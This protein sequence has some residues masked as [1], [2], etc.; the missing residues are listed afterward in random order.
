MTI[1]GF[2]FTAAAL[3]GLALANGAD[4]GQSASADTAPSV[5]VN[6]ADLNISDAAGAKALMLR[7]K[8]AAAEVCGYYSDG[9]D[10][11]TAGAVRRCMTAAVKDAVAQVDQKQLAAGK[12]LEHPLLVASAKA[13][14]Y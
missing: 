13:P 11:T 3:A 4:A 10:V 5:R 9:W 8:S 6:Y 14:S 12:P 1:R 2:F 7:L